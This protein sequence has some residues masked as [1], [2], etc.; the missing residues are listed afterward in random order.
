MQR[1]GGPALFVL[2]WST[3]FVGAKYGLPYAEPFTLLALRMVI[4]AVL[5]AALAAALRSAS[6]SSRRSYRHAAVVGLFLHAGYLGGVFYA[7]SVGVPA[8]VSAVVVS[9]QPVLTAVLASRV[10]GE[11]LVPRQWVGLALGVAGVAMVVGPGV[12]STAGRAGALPARGLLA[13]LV[14]LASGTVATLYQ[15]RHG[16]GIPLVWGTAV[17]Y[18]AAGALLLALAGSTE[19][20]VL[21]WTPQLVGALVWLVLVLSLGAVLLLLL[22]LRRGTASG[23]SSLLYLV[24]PAVA[25]EAYVM[26]GERLP[27]LSLLGVGVTAAGVALVVTPVRR[28]AD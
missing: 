3:G 24:P 2:L 4:A 25:V 26:F 11:R 21:R 28:R 9:L 23:V 20:M 19:S 5:L 27:P 1:V 16:D 17:Q 12:V 6:M 7:I 10:L 14:A 8:G 13:C 22:L 15:K 18:A